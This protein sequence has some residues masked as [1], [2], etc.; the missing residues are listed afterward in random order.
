VPTPPTTYQF[1]SDEWLAAATQIRDEV[2]ETTSAPVALSMNLT[3]TDAPFSSTNV[4]V[5]LDTSRGVL[6][7]ARGHL[8]QADVTIHVD[9]ATAKSLLLDGDTTVAMSAFMAGKVTVEGD[10]A[11]LVSLQNTPVDAASRE[12]VER[13]RAITA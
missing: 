7:L 4:L 3:V 13:L 2:G 10:M 1:L 11:K 9:W 5:A 6:A 12:V 8:D